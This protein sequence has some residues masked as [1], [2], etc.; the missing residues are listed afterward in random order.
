M[1]TG[2]DPL[3]IGLELRLGRVSRENVETKGRRYL[4][5]GRLRIRRVEPSCIVA[6]CRGTE[7]THRVAFEHGEWFCTCPARGR[8][9]HLVALQLVVTRGTP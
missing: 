6:S 5:E 2:I 8:C 9:S 3:A 4:V 1:S 7:E